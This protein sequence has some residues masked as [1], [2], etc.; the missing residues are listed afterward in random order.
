MEL[1]ELRL[2]ACIDDIA[3]DS[4]AQGLDFGRGSLRSGVLQP[5]AS[6]LLR[7]PCRVA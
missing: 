6:A 1:L 4:F 3:A 7:G 2:T 5:P